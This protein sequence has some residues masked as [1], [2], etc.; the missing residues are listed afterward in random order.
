MIEKIAQKISAELKKLSPDI[1]EEAYT[2]ALADKER[3][4][5]CLLPAGICMQIIAAYSPAFHRREGFSALMFGTHML[6]LIGAWRLTKDV[7][8]LDETVKEAIL[9]TPLTGNLPV[10]L[11]FRMP[12]WCMYVEFMT[13][14]YLGFFFAL[15]KAEE[16]ELR[17]WWVERESLEF[18]GTPVRLGNW[19]LQEALEKAEKYAYQ[20]TGFSGKYESRYL[21]E[22]INIIVYLCAENAEYTQGSALPS[23]PQPKKTKR[24]IRFFPADKPR[25]WHVGKQ[26]GERLR[27]EFK[28]VGGNK[29][30]RP[31]IRRAH[32]HG[33]WTG[34]KAAEQ[35]DFIVKWI[36]PVFVGGNVDDSEKNK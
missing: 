22:A 33:Y 25:I 16:P 34:P 28:R 5:W 3:P 2:A 8:R 20:Y 36:P 31:H 17:I 18:V 19:T 7:V 32:W 6:S 29:G 30:R 26:L 1:F 10:D 27:A 4:S 13:P 24:G 11:F 35:R 14:E 23:R 21:T 9:A 15:E 12:A